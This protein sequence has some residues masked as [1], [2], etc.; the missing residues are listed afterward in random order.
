LGNGLTCVQI[1]EAA[2][3]DRYVA[4]Q[5]PQADVEAL[6]AHY[7]TCA[8]CQLEIR[9]AV[10]TR[11][12]LADVKG[13]RSESV[14]ELIRQ[15][16]RSAAPAP[17]SL[18]GNRRARS[19]RGRWWHGAAAAGLASAAII[20]GLMIVRPWAPPA[21]APSTHRA[22]DTAQTVPMLIAPSGIVT[23][24]AA[25]TW[26]SVADADRYR[27]TIYSAGGDVLGEF[28]TR[29]TILIRSD[30]PVLQQ[31]VQYLWVVAARLGWDRW[32]SSDVASFTLSRPQP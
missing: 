20:A 21:P 10:A 28:E 1:T 18:V 13:S 5:L 4:R 8:R 7:L 15:E 11:D 25:F 22:D 29:D 30:A 6:E 31:E 16:D 14:L 12:A 9:L 27:V 17:D 26:A 23:E 24:F 2:F 32:V 19:R 3:V